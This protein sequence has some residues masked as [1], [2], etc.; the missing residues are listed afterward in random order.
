MNQLNS[1]SSA[2]L[3]GALVAAAV[4]MNKPPPS[5]PCEINKQALESIERQNKNLFDSNEDLRKAINKL[6]EDKQKFIEDQVKAQ[7]KARELDEKIAEAEKAKRD[8]ER[9]EQAAKDKPCQPA[10]KPTAQQ[11]SDDNGGNSVVRQSLIGKPAQWHNDPQHPQLSVY[12]GPSFASFD[13]G[14]K[15]TPIPK[16][17]WLF[18]TGVAVL[19]AIKFWA[20]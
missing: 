18:G 16:S 4:Q 19:A 17:A 3:G 11:D 2:L 14:M 13:G 7:T 15:Q 9:A 1:V 12:G 20:G 8:A 10:S 6:P 5:A